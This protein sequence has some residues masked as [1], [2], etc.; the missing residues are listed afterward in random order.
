MRVRFFQSGEEAAWDAFCAVSY[1][2]TFLHTRRFL[3]YHGDRF[4]D[5][6]LVFEDEHRW[7][8]VLPAAAHPAS[9]GTVSSHPGITYGG[10]VHDG[11]LRGEAMIAALR[12]AARVYAEAGLASLQ[13][14]AT[15][16]IYHAA[17]AQDD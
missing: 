7:V 2:A 3:S 17:P 12:E 6:S 14:K 15:P 9:A 13:Y 10:I 16:H 8:G 11:A 1:N 4:Q 5:R